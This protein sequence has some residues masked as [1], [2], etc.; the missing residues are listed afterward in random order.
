MMKYKETNNNSSWLNHS[1]A[2]DHFCS[3]L[4]SLYA[5]FIIVFAI[6]VELSQ[7]FTSDEWLAETIFFSYMYGIGILFIFYCYLFKVQHP[8]WLNNLIFKKSL[9]LKEKN[10]KITEKCRND[11]AG[12]L[13]L[14]LGTLCF[15]SSGIVLFCLEMFICH[16]N[17]QCYNYRFIN[18]L[19]AGF[20]TFIQMHFIFC[21]SRLIIGDSKNLIKFGTMHLLSINIWTWLRFVIAKSA[22]LDKKSPFVELKIK[23][24]ILIDSSSESSEELLENLKNKLSFNSSNNNLILPLRVSSFNYFGDFATLLTTCI[25][26]YSVIGAAIMITI[27]KSIDNNLINKSNKSHDE[28]YFNLLTPKPQLPKNTKN[29]RID[30]SASSGGLFA[31]LLFLIASFVSIGI[32]SFFSQH[33]DPDGALL[34]FRLSDMALFCCT[35]IGCSV[36]LFRMNSLQ[37]QPHEEQ[38]STNTEFLDEILLA[39]GLVGELIHSSTGVMC[40]ISTQS[41]ASPIKMEL[42]M[43]FVFITRIMQVV[44]QAVFILLSRRL[45]ALSPKTRREKPGKQFVTFLLISNVSLFFFHTLEGMKSR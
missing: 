19:L 37:Y 8:I 36:G 21:N 35:L 3:V 32:H 44:V 14:R 20:F 31:G 22:D 42:Y 25:V 6:V 11:G 39:I 43:L 38:R 12:S 18:W 10:N 15:G 23:N 27:W 7:E 29:I 34:V 30:C 5:L 45:R 24:R 17:K 40:W 4:T 16:S 9:I 28:E 26:E 13:Y 41:E 1:P 33:E 2:W